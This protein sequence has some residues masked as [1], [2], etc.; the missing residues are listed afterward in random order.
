MSVNDGIESPNV[1]LD[2]VESNTKLHDAP[3]PADRW[4]LPV[5]GRLVVVAGL[6]FSALDIAILRHGRFIPTAFETPGYLL[7]L[8]GLGLYVVG[9]LILGRFYS[10]SVRI[11]PEHKLITSGPYRIIRHPI[12]FGGDS[13]EP[14]NPADP[15]QSLRIFHHFGPDTIAA[16]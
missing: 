13:P 3:K 10:E 6:A 11:R 12:Y 15:R 16:S 14:F 4:L 5:V 1:A 9:R 7:F 8:A 2:R